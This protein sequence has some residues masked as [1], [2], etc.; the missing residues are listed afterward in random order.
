MSARRIAPLF[1]ALLLA[2]PLVTSRLDAA[3]NFDSKAALAR[4]HEVAGYIVKVQPGP[5]WP[6]LSPRMREAMHDSA[7]LARM[8]AGIQ[9]Q[10]G[11]LDSMAGDRVEEE[12][13]LLVYKA[14]CRFSKAP[15]PLVLSVSFDDEGR[16]AGMYVKQAGPPPTAYDSPHLSYLT[17]TPLRLPFRGEWTVIWG[18]RTIE[19][20]YHA[21]TRDQR[22]ALDLLIKKDG[23]SHAGDGSKLTDYYCYGEPVLS[24]AAGR[25]VWLRDSLSDNQPGGSDR[26]N[27]TGN[28]VIV[29]HGNKEYSLFAHMQPNTLRFKLGDPVKAG[30]VLG[31]CGNSGNTSEPHIH[32]H[33]QDTPVFH[34]G[35]GLPPRFLDLF[36]N[37]VHADTAEVVKGQRIRPAK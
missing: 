18:G 5:L 26:K 36:V 4:G 28:S 23:K 35:D 8:L 21:R 34:E 3:G 12:G 27:P 22:F 30:D 10:T 32:Y 7:S 14:D 16:V 24:P 29:D 6:M 1:V 37:D 9:A 19:Q 33:L 25:I 11:T 20:N 13:G 31:L 17:K 2:A 15:V